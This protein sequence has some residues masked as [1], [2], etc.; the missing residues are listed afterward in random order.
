MHTVLRVVSVHTASWIEGGGG[1]GGGAY[2]RFFSLKCFYEHV[3][4]LFLFITEVQ[5]ERVLPHAVVSSLFATISLCAE[6]E[7]I[8]PHSVVSS[9]FC[10]HLIMCRQRDSLTSCRRIIAILPSS[11]H[12]QAERQSY[13]MPSYHRHFAII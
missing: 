5:A 4:G 11:D 6:R 12:V 13:L 8:L 3:F 9:L 2:R 10:H 1:G 7:T